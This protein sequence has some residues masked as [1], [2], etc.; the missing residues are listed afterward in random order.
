M[1]HRLS[2]SNYSHLLQK[3]YSLAVWIKNDVDAY[4]V[5]GGNKYLKDE[6]AILSRYQAQALLFLSTPKLPKKVLFFQDTSSFKVTLLVPLAP[7]L[8]TSNWSEVDGTPQRE[9]EVP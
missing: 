9:A 8:R 5:F 3:S 6:S 4:R 1:E 2:N 7:G